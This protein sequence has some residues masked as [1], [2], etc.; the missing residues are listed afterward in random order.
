MAFFGGCWGRKN[1]RMGLATDAFVVEEANI[2][3]FTSLSAVFQSAIALPSVNAQYPCTNKITI[4]DD[5]FLFQYLLALQSHSRAKLV[6]A[7]LC[8]FH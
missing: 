3:F 2:A 4:R 7:P 1:G 8:S 6:D 5:F